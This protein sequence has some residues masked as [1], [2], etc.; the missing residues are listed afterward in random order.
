M[1]KSSSNIFCTYSLESGSGAGSGL[2]R[3]RDG[4]DGVDFGVADVEGFGVADGADFGVSDDVG[5]D[6]FSDCCCADDLFGGEDSGGLVCEYEEDE[7]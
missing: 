5:C 3:C 6:V 2:N 1:E 7:E 4:A